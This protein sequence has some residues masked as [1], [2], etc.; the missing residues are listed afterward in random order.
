MA[1]KSRLIKREEWGEEMA[2]DYGKRIWLDRIDTGR[3]E[4]QVW[5]D[6]M[7]QDKFECIAAAGLLLSA[8]EKA[9]LAQISMANAC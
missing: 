2:W 8:I 6:A 4:R 1:L 7:V 3:T 5:P 9:H